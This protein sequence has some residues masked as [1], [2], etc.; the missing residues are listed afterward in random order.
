VSA[1][2]V[3]FHTE[4]L[5]S[6]W[7]LR[8]S[9]DRNA[10]DVVRSHGTWYLPGGCRLW[11]HLYRLIMSDGTK[12]Y[13]AEPYGITE[14]SFDDLLRLRDAGWTIKIGGV[15]FWNPE[16]PTTRILLRR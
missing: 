16:W 1:K 6:G 13:C 7:R 4:L 15:A 5:P 14:E 10:P 9:W 2:S 12:C 3:G 11:D 8:P